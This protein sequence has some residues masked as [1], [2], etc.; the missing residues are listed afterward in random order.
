MICVLADIIA[1]LALHF[2]DFPI[3]AQ[4]LKRVEFLDL[5][6]GG[7]CN[8]AIT[9][10]RLS[11][12]VECL[13]E[14]GDDRF[15]DLVREGLQAEGIGTSHLM[16][17]PG[18][19]TPVA[20]VL[21]DRSGE[22]AYL[23]FRGTLR[24]QELEPSWR[25]QITAAEALFVDGWADHAWVPDI[26][27]EGLRVAQT[28]GVSSYFD[29]GPG[30][31]E[32][33]LEW[34]REA[35]RLSTVLLLN[36]DEAER[37]GGSHNPAQSLLGAGP[38]LVVIKQGAAGCSVHTSERSFRQPGFSVEARDLT[39]AGDSFDAAVI[40]AHQREFELEQL[41]LLANATGAAKVRKRG[42]GHNMPTR[43]QVQQVLAEAGQLLSNWPD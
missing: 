15:G 32:F 3:M 21:V 29:P 39:G 8:V 16:V 12:A 5:R 42:T 25:Q 43:E 31:P 18:A 30:N 1:D 17:S 10:A 27:L 36:Q 35:V 40:Y 22:P 7:A 13:G 26:V 41:A 2:G 11:M 38:E 19:R 24:V 37:L 9:L 34:Q 20:G 23:G 33:D 28:A 14:I 4:D 6:P